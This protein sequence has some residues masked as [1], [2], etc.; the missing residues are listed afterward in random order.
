VAPSPEKSQNRTLPS[1]VPPRAKCPTAATVC[2]QLPHGSV[3]TH[4]H[5]TAS[6]TFTSADMHTDT[7][8]NRMLSGSRGSPTRNQQRAAQ[9]LTLAVL[10]QDPL[11]N[12]PLGRNTSEVTSSV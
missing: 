11:T 9:S 2:T 7:C 12:R 3:D 1:S 8:H 5:R 10:S 6:H 4:S